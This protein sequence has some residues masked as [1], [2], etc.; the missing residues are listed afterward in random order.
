VQP[1]NR[2]GNWYVHL[3]RFG[4]RQIA[5]ATSERSL[6]TVLLPARRLRENIES[7][8]HTAVAELLTA[9]KLPTS[10]VGRELAAMQ[11]ISF[12][13]ASNRRVIG[14]IN[15]FVWQLENYMTRTVNPLILSLRL[16]DTP[17]SAVG[18]K[19]NL[20]FPR[21]VARDLLMTWEH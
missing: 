17:M 18:A 14:S 11:P 16:S 12:A 19:S 7:D 9:L 4:H 21:E 6:L 2:L 15:E 13:V 10:V 3:A 1:S 5:L 8:F 20:A